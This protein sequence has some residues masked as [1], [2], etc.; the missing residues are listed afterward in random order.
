MHDAKTN[1]SRLV[2]RAQAGE[3]IVIARHGKP[4]VRL[5]PVVSGASLGSVHGVWHGQVRIGDDFDE[6]PSDIADAFGAV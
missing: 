5:V 4:A 6:L 1:L 2:A 3:D